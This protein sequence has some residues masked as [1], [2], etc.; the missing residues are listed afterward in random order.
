MVLEIGDAADQTRVA[1]FELTLPHGPFR[2]EA[3]LSKVTDFASV[4]PA[5][6]VSIGLSSSGKYISS[7]PAAHKDALIQRTRNTEDVQVGRFW[8]HPSI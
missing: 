5:S 6:G 4:G 3:S 1:V 7:I 8:G 2:S